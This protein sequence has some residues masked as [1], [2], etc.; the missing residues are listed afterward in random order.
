MSLV[1]LCRNHSL[2]TNRIIPKGTML[3]LYIDN[4]LLMAHVI[5]AY[6]AAN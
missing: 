4:A 2:A 1:M 3:L 5:I 6:A